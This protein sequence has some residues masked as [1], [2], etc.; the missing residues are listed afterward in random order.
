MSKRGTRKSFIQY[1]LPTEALEKVQG[2]NKMPVVT[3][4]ALGEEGGTVTTKAVGE[5][6]GGGGPITTLALGEE[7]GGSYY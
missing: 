6:C 2:G 4:L 1:E 7:G 5:E 3:T